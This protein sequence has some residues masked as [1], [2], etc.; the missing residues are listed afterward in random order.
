MADQIQEWVPEWNPETKVE[1][2]QKKW[3]ESLSD[4]TSKFLAN[5]PYG[6]QV[7]QQLFTGSSPEAEKIHQ[8]FLTKHGAP[9]GETTGPGL[10]KIPGVEPATNWL[11]HQV[12][13]TDSPFYTGI[14]PALAGGLKFIGDTIAS[15]F[16]PRTAFPGKPTP[17]VIPSEPIK[18]PLALGPAPT[19]IANP[20]KFIAGPSSLESPFASGEVASSNVKPDIAAKIAGLDTGGIPTQTQSRFNPAELAEQKRQSNLSFGQAAQ[21]PGQSI[22]IASQRTLPLESGDTTGGFNEQTS[23][24]GKL[25]YPL[26]IT[27]NVLRPRTSQT[28]LLG[29]LPESTDLT[30]PEQGSNISFISG[31]PDNIP[32]VV[33]K[34]PDYY[35][36]QQIPNASDN[37]PSAIRNSSEQLESNPAIATSDVPKPSLDR[38][39]N[40]PQRAT[41]TSDVILPKP[42]TPAPSKDVSGFAANFRSPHK[43]LL[44]KPETASIAEM[45]LNANDEKLQWTREKLDHLVTLTQGL[46]KE[47]R[48]ELGQITEGVHSI[49]PELLNRAQQ[50]KRILDNVFHDLPEGT[51]YIDRYLT[52]IEKQPEDFQVAAKQIFDWH[53]ITGLFENKPIGEDSKGLGDMFEKGLGNPNSPFVK[54]RSDVI[55]N[56]EYDVNK[57]WPAYVESVAKLVFDKP[58]VEASKKII[59]GLSSSNLKELAQWYIKNY[60]RYDAEQGLHKAWNGFVD[61]IARTTARSVIA[62]NPGLHMLHL[63]EI[64][65]NIFP[66]LGAKYTMHGIKEVASKPMSTWSEMARLGLLQSEIRPFGFK[67][68]VEKFDSISYGLSYIESLVKGIAYNGAKAKFID[69]GL[70]EAAASLKALRFAKDSTF[71]VDAARQ[72]KGFSPESNAVGGEIG[73]RLGGQFKQIPAKIVEQF[74][75]ISKRAAQNSTMAARLYAGTGIALAGAGIGAH[76]YHVNPTSLLTTATFGPFSTVLGK[77][78][79]DLFIKHDA[80]SALKEVT[81]WATPGG[82]NIKKAYEEI[83]PSQKSMNLKIRKLKP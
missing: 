30:T 61:Q 59:E 70:D 63:G 20:P 80:P 71:T 45:I 38:V 27:P 83:N 75:D 57:I 23:D 39:Q 68:A 10:M 74:F 6:R 22:D 47:E 33:K 66:E 44:E 11:E 9:Q 65:A 43:V 15:G 35:T 52:H 1:E 5:H 56:L 4:S 72:M 34:K 46:S 77:V 79:Y 29:K 58:A 8:E 42:G 62:F 13:P 31:G 82:A 3:Y 37:L 19:H 18:E 25:D 53:K 73:S 50:A 40:A 49:N 2:T 69:E 60:T 16:D 48:I 26:N 24:S 7:L 21:N 28:E 81:I 78:G 32:E 51:G 67:T 12:D 64:P 76:T 14:R 17:E 55:D 36:G 54:H 41:K